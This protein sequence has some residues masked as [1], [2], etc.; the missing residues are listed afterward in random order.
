MEPFVSYAVLRGGDAGRT[1][2]LRAFEDRLSAVWGESPLR[3]HSLDD[4]DD[5][6]QLREDVVPKTPG[7]WRP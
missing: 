2:L 4:Y 7:Q 1:G 3:F 6:Q 5:T